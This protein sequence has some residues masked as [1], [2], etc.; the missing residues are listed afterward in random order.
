MGKVVMMD[1]VMGEPPGLPKWCGDG[2]GWIISVGLVWSEMKVVICDS[3]SQICLCS[4]VILKGQQDRLNSV[5]VRSQHGDEEMQLETGAWLCGKD[6]PRRRMASI[7]LRCFFVLLCLFLLE[8]QTCLAGYQAEYN[9]GK[10][11]AVDL[12]YESLCPYCANFIA[13]LLPPYSKMVLLTSSISTFILGETPKLYQATLFLARSASHG[14]SEC[15]LN[16]IDACALH[17]W[18]RLSEH[19]P[20]I[21]CVE[22]LVYKHKYSEWE[23]CFQTLALD[24]KPVMGCYSSG[25]GKELVLKYGAETNALDPPKRYVPWVVV[26]GQPLYEEY[27]EFMSYVCKAYKGTP[28]SAC[29]ELSHSLGS[30][31]EKKT[32]DVNPIHYSPKTEKEPVMPREGFAIAM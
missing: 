6:G 13:N 22:S 11:V 2:D 12:Y 9:S 26:D 32:S 28:P 16:E 20:F 19:F 25:K 21:Y 18:P 30:V 17:V 27:D 10:K 1:A 4:A 23:T 8:I 5:M 14:P 31:G 24:P 7:R 29:S 3:N 15:L